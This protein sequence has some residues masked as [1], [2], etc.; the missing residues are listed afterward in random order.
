M[1]D[2]LDLMADLIK[3]GISVD[4]AR[5]LVRKRSGFIKAREDFR[6]KTGLL[7]D[8]LKKKLSECGCPIQHRDGGQCV[9]C[10]EIY[11]ERGG[12]GYDG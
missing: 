8:A 7:R 6:V 3:G 9:V 12:S 1:H 11:Q 2:D 10:G 5:K 4:D